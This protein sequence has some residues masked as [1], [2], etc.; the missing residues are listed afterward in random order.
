MIIL[1]LC[2]AN[3]SI[4]KPIPVI[5]ATLVVADAFGLLL[6]SHTE[7]TRSIRPSSIINIYLFVTIL[8]DAARLRTLW[9]QHAPK[10]LASVCSATLAIKVIIA[11]TEAME[12]RKIL[13]SQYKNVSPEA[14]SGLY[15]RAFFWWLNKILGIGFRRVIQDSDL[16]PVED[17]ISSTRLKKR[18]QSLW[19]KA[20]KSRPHVLFWTT[21]N[22]NRTVLL[23]GVFPR[24]CLIG[25]RY[26]QPFLLSRTVEFVDSEQADNIGWG[27]AGAFFVVFLGTAVVGAFY[28]HMSYRFI[29]SLRGTLITMIYA[30]TVDLSITALDESAAMTLMSNDT[31]RSSLFEILEASVDGAS[32]L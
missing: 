5:A 14:T 11:I 3:S 23:L 29:T 10:P 1:V 19:E 13:V 16:F 17:E 7:H 31:G 28:S 32:R 15:G 4:R 25:L 9:I 24:I 2:A 6:L 30:K 20:N 8:F 27:L 22:T 12:K 26:A 18:S 21:L